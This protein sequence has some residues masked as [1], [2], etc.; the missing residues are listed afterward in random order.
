MDREGN[1]VAV[2]GSE[3]GLVTQ[4]FLTKFRDGFNQYN[5]TDNWTEVSK[6]TGDIV[7]VDGNA[8]GSSYLV[9]SKSSLNADT[10]TVLETQKV[11]TMPFELSIGL[12]I[13]QRTLAQDTH[14]EFV[15][16]DPTDAPVEDIT[17]SA[18]QQAT[19]ILTVTTST[20]HGLVP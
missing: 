16:T 4:N 6:G 2:L 12:S 8:G 15:D 1:P 10:E 5:T 17:I 7:Q 3:D 18:I 13:S 11:F 20:P 19:T 9:I 14:I